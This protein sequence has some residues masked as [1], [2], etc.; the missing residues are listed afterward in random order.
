M[1]EG[2][3]GMSLEQKERRRKALK[4]KDLA[5]EHLRGFSLGRAVA[6]LDDA[7]RLCP[8][9]K[10]LW[11]NRSHVHE[12][13]KQHEL[14]LADAK[15]CVQLDPA[16]P[17]GYLR[18]GRAL[19][20]MERNGEAEETLGAGRKLMPTDTTLIDAHKEAK[21]LAAC[22]ERDREAMRLK[23]KSTV[24]EEDIIGV[25]RGRCKK[26]GCSCNAYIQKHG[27]TTVLLQGRGMV[28]NDNDTRFFA[29][30]RCGH[31]VIDHV[32][33]RKGADGKLGK[34]PSRPDGQ[35]R[36]WVSSLWD[37]NV[38]GL[39]FKPK[40]VGSERVRF[41][42]KR[43]GSERVGFQPKR[44]GSERAGSEACLLEAS[45]S[46]PLPSHATRREPP[47]HVSRCHTTPACSYPAATIPRLSRPARRIVTR[48]KAPATVWTRSTTMPRWGRRGRRKG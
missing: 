10:E 46:T 47:P 25:L 24:G 32:D 40:H 45:A 28:C 1:H 2:E 36:I 43:V 48:R 44:V 16:W 42:P 38:W 4:L 35:V 34:K 5:S 37:R 41:K 31:D 6:Y 17:K 13:A 14:A 9:M 21:F 29:C 20:S 23:S 22:Q 15:R 27:R 12:T 18:A 8:D 33:L 19:M 7:I 39:G 26:A 30:V 11:S 3:E